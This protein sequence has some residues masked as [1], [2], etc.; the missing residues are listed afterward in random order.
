MPSFW[1]EVPK[2]FLKII[3]E[4]PNKSSTAHQK[5][6]LTTR[7]VEHLP[8]ESNILGMKSPGG[9]FCSSL[10]RWRKGD[11]S[12]ERLMIPID[13]GLNNSTGD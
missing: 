12:G 5:T 8:A 6:S 3:V 13:R 9:A 4:A 7:L 2:V 10:S 1:S 11:S